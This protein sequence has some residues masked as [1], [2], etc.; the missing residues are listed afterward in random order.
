MRVTVSV[1]A[2][3]AAVQ[4]GA[5]DDYSERLGY[6]TNHTIATSFLEAPVATG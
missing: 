5:Y 2:V 4:A 1:D 3:A 6:Y